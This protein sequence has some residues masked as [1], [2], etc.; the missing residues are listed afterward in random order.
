ME[1]HL[2]DECDCILQDLIS[3]LDELL[4]LMKEEREAIFDFNLEQITQTSRKKNDLL[5]RV[6]I[7]DSAKSASYNKLAL[8]LG[9]KNKPSIEFILSQLPDQEMAN[10]LR[11]RLSCLKSLAQAT[12]EYNELQRQ[13]IVSSL[14]SIQ[15]SLVVLGKMNS[16]GICYNDKA[17]I[18]A[19]KKIPIKALMDHSY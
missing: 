9:Y 19:Q 1:N 11:H 8:S 3:V 10:K 13:H 7:L 18:A 2:F 6:K 14:S 17:G 16:D 5:L 12:Q 4:C 15:S